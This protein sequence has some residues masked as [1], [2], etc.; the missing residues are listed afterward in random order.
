MVWDPQIFS[1]YVF[2]YLDHFICPAW[3]VK[4]FEGLV[5]EEFPNCGN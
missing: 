1:Y 3:V 4:I 5:G 2:T